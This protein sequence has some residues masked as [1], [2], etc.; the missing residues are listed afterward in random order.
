MCA[1]ESLL[2][3]FPVLELTEEPLVWRENLGLR[4]L[5]ALYLNYST[6]P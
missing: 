5:E 4:G 2:R 6:H 3:R 1:F